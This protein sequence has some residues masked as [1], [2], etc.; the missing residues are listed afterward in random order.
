MDE[1][2]YANN[3]WSVLVTINQNNRQSEFETEFDAKF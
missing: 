1:E 3:L 2:I